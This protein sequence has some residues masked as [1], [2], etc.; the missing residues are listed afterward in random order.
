MPAMCRCV[1]AQPLEIVDP[2]PALRSVV[3]FIFVIDAVPIAVNIGTIIV[4]IFIFIL[5]TVP[6]RVFI[7]ILNPVE[8]GIRIAHDIAE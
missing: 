2:D 5:T 6:V 8:V 7:S 1:V 4:I 3:V